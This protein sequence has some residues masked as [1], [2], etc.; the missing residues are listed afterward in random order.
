MDDGETMEI[1]RSHKDR[2]Q[3]PSAIDVHAL[4]PRLWV[5]MIPFAAPFLVFS[6]TV[7]EALERTGP[8]GAFIAAPL[9]SAT[10]IAYLALIVVLKKH[11]I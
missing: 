10:S 4:I 9:L 2:S 7:C 5:I 8:I 11:K 1:A 6:F 3:D